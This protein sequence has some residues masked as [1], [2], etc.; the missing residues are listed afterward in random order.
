M[1]IRALRGAP[2]GAQPAL[3]RPTRMDCW[4]KPR[5]RLT[6]NRMEPR[7]ERRNASDRR[8]PEDRRRAVIRVA[9]EQ[10]SGTDRRSG[11]DRRGPESLSDQIRSALE[12]LTSVAESGTLDETSL[13]DL[14]QAVF[15]LRFAL[16]RFERAR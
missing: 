10:R 16:D 15:R 9:V 12:L 6:L 4:P 1:K 3:P 7:A 13:R 5:A 8:A 14:D 11:V 2:N